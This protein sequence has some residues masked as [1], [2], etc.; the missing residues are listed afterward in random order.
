MMMLST[1]TNRSSINLQFLHLSQR[2]CTQTSMKLFT[3]QAHDYFLWQLNGLRTYQVSQVFHLEIR[4]ASK[5]NIKYKFHFIQFITMQCTK[6]K[7]RSE[8]LFSCKVL[9]TI[10]EYFVGTLL[11]NNRVS[12]RRL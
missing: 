9:V 3:K 10:F 2:I 8:K 11:F 12:F 7:K 1:M 5:I 6:Q 4:Y